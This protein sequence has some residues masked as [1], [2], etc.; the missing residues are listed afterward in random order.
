MTASIPR[1]AL[2]ILTALL[3]LLPQKPSA[4]SLIEALAI[5]A[6][7]SGD[8][9]ALLAVAHRWQLME[10]SCPAPAPAPAIPAAAPEPTTGCLTLEEMREHVLTVMRGHA[11]AGKRS[12]SIYDIQKGIDRLIRSGPGWA[13]E[14]LQDLNEGMLNPHGRHVEHV[15]WK[16]MLTTCM[17][18]MRR[19]GEVRNP[20]RKQIKTYVLAARLS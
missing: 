20:S 2:G 1:P 13:A 5:D 11:E 3:R 4:A 19:A 9:A 17:M 18:E 10:G 15:R 6:I 8:P 7:R 16:R 14:D 12:S